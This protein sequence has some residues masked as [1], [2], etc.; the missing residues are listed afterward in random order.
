MR[1]G[2]APRDARGTAKGGTVQ[3]PSPQA[4]ATTT[5]AAAWARCAAVFRPAFFAEAGLLGE[6]PRDPIMF[7]ILAALPAA[8][9]A[10][11]GTFRDLPRLEKLIGA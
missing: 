2:I 7:S 1:G 3:A 6:L 11:L 9:R 8:P 10:A 5:C 4:Q